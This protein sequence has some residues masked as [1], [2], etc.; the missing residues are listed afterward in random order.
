MTNN[1]NINNML[2]DAKILEEVSMKWIDRPSATEMTKIPSA[3]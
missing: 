1:Q 3:T 2:N